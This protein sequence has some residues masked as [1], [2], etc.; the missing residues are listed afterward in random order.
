M[1]A[2]LDN[3]YNN[4]YFFFQINFFCDFHLPVVVQHSPLP[5]ML[6]SSTFTNGSEKT[7][8]TSLTES[9]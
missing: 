7:S 8:H 6:L 3:A 2:H 9:V 1:L 5:A 4:K